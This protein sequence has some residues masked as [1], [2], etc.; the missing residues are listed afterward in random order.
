MPGLHDLDPVAELSLIRGFAD[1][2]P[3][4]IAELASCAVQRRVPAQEVASA[5]GQVAAGTFFL[6]RGAAKSVRTVSTSQGTIVRVIDVMR[7]SSVI[8]DASVIDGQPSDA[9]LVALRSSQFFVVDRRALL[10]VMAAHPSLE[11]ALF[12]RFV[13]QAR[14]LVRRIDELASGTVEDRVHR[15]FEAL[16]SQHGTPL[17]QGRFIAL[18]LR[19]RDIASMVNA[20]TETVSRLLAK[21]ERE[22]KARSTRDGIWWRAGGKRSSAEDA[23]PPS[24][25]RSLPPPSSPS[26][27][28]LDD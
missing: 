7:A 24:S 6:V 1:V 9:D 13:R 5:Q 2:A 3:D 22:G 18:P 27:P 19:R 28:D 10:R 21:L 15:L 12:S 23:T 8:A 4:A 25:D 11:Q 20:T 26:S 17:G 16:A 14:T